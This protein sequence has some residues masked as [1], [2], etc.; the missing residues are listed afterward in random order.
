M[1]ILLKIAVWLLVFAV[2][3]LIRFPYESVLSHAMA[4]LEADSGIVVNWQDAQVGLGS[5][6][7]KG[8]SVSIPSGSRFQADKAAVS[9][10][11]GGMKI[12]FTQND[13]TAILKQTL[14]LSEAESISPSMIPPDEP[15]TASLR[16]AAPSVLSFESENLVVD[17]GSKSLQAI[18]LS[19]NMNIVN[20]EGKGV[21]NLKVPYLKIDA[22]PIP[23]QNIEIG[24]TVTM[25]PVKGKNN[26]IKPSKKKNVKKKNQETEAEET[27]TE[28]TSFKIVN[29]IT[30]FNDQATGEGI[31]TMITSPRG[32]SP[33]LNGEI[34]LK[35]KTLGT[36]KV[37]IGGTWA[38]PEWNLAGA[39]QQ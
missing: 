36:H 1:K 20:Y 7:M 9:V 32:D 29:K 18:V 15:G 34:E 35:T 8:L 24:S 27:G 39:N 31:V 12:K 38:N 25:T 37:R 14:N 16:A 22:L 26:Q 19:G 3:L 5:M 21:I 13:P 33:S 17:T 4:K 23:L 30:L 28:R 11:K 6:K 10:I 2:V